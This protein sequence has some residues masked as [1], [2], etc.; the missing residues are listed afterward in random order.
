MN[1]VDSCGWLEYF[2]D[3]PNSG[4]F[5]PAIEEAENL[6]IPSISI[7]EVFKCVLRQRSEHEAFQAI[8]LLQRGTVVD[9]DVNIAIQAG[10][11]SHDYKLPLADS[12]ILATAYV[13]DTCIWTQDT[14]FKKFECVK[15]VDK[16]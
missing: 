7:L 14:H 3:G 16:R 13:Y 6:I 10:R 9:M 4:F 5:A 1:I 8:A 12:V 2:A 11:F 15:Y